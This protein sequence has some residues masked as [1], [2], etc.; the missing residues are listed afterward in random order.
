MRAEKSAPRPTDHAEAHATLAGLLGAT[1]P[2]AT[3]VQGSIG[4]CRSRR[5]RFG[6]GP[7]IA[8]EPARWLDEGDEVTVSDLTL[9]CADCHRPHA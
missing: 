7:A 8:F 4:A 1:W 2:R 5:R 6:F 3:A 9:A